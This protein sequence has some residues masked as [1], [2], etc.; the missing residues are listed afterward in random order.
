M[1]SFY[2]CMKVSHEEFW[3]KSFGKFL[4][5]SFGISWKNFW[6]NKAR[7]NQYLP[8]SRIQ[9]IFELFVYE[10]ANW[11]LKGLDKI[12]TCYQK[13]A[14]NNVFH[15]FTFHRIGMAESLPSFGTTRRL[16]ARET[17][18]RKLTNLLKSILHGATLLVLRNNSQLLLPNR[19]SER[20]SEQTP[21]AG[22]SKY[23]SKCTTIP[24]LYS[25]QTEASGAVKSLFSFW[26]SSNVLK[27]KPKKS[28]W[29]LHIF[30]CVASVMLLASSSSS[31]VG[32]SHLVGHNALE[33]PPPRLRC[34]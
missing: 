10:L 24:N 34:K 32:R 11:S 20:S 27:L 1:E 33:P 30:S 31:S 14:V 28:S 3:K 8:L 23:T 6:R 22:D 26:L 19:V 13:S 18:N 25:S 12:Q 5:K 16:I 15:R 9:T 7:L 2:K 17:F 29:S 4:K 21:A